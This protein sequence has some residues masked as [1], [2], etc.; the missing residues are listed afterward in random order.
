MI[1]TIAFPT[2]NK[3]QHFAFDCL[4]RGIDVEP[5]SPT[6]V[7]VTYQD[8]EKILDSVFKNEGNVLTTN[9]AQGKR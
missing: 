3:Q 6:A 5:L 7:T 1:S 8:V 2:H 4:L 9:V